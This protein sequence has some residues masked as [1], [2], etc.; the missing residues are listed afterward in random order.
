MSSIPCV[1]IL[2][3]LPRSPNR[4]DGPKWTCG[5]QLLQRPCVVFSLGCADIIDF[6]KELF[7]W[8]GC[9]IHVFDPTVSGSIAP[10]LKKQAGRRRYLSHS[11]H[12]WV[13]QH[14]GAMCGS[15]IGMG[16]ASVE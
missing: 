8:G 13:A 14:W 10:S 9:A 2:L 16:A 12:G 4:N 3:C 5:V 1:S 15:G 6:E 11:V 7:K